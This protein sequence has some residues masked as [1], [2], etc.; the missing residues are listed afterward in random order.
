MSADCSRKCTCNPKGAVSCETIQ[1]TTGCAVQNG[2]QICL[3]ER[4]SDNGTVGFNGGRKG[5][6]GVE[7]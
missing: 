3:D 4:E 6:N 5:Q 2:A 7:L 1:C